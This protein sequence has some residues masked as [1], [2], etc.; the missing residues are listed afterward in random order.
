VKTK[1]FAS[2]KLGFKIFPPTS[3]KAL[4]EDVS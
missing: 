4:D 3:V 1:N 2:C